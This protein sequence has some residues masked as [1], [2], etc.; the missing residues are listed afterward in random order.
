MPIGYIPDSFG[1]I[2]AIPTILAG[3]GMDTA[4]VY[5]GFGGEP[6]QETSEY[7]WVGPD[8]TRCLM[9]HLFRNGYS[10]GYFHQESD[11]EIV[12]RFTALKE[13]LDA[14]ATTSHRLLLNGGDH[15]WPDPRLPETIDLLTRSFPGT[16]VHSTLPAYV[17]GVKA[18]RGTLPE[19]R[20]E[21][22][23]GYRY[24]FAVLGGIYSSRMPIKQANWH[25]QHLLQRYAEPLNALAVTQ[26]MRT[27]LPLLHHAWNSLMQNHPHDS[28]CGCSIDPVHR[29]METRFAAVKDIGRAIV[30]ASLDHVIPYDDLASRDDRY[31]FFFNPTPW[32]RS[33]VVPAE[34]RFFRQDIVVGL[35][36]DVQVERPLPRATGFALVDR[37]GKEV[38]YQ[39]LSRTDGYDLTTT[40]FNYPKQT[41]A[42]CFSLLVDARC[43]P[44]I[45][46]AGL[47]VERRKSFPRYPARV[48]CGN[49]FLENEALRVDVN[50]RGEITLT[51]KARNIVYPGLGVC[52]DTGDV[53]DE[54]NYA[55]PR[56]DRRILSSAG[57]IRR[58]LAE[59]GPLR[60]TLRLDAQ[61]VLPAEAAPGRA[62][63]SRSTVKVPVTLLLHLSAD[64]RTLEIEVTVDNRARDHRFRILFP[65]G[66]GSRVSVADA[67][68][69]LAERTQ[70]EYDLRSFTIEH[71][72]RVAPMQRFVFAAGRGRALA[73]LAEGLPE[74]ELMTDRR[75][76]L[77]VTLL[78]SVGLL[79]GEDLLTRP[80][81]KSGWHNETPDAQCPG[82][83]SFR[84]AVLPLSGTRAEDLETLNEE[85]ERFHLPL[86]PVRRKNPESLPLE[87]SLLSVD[88][89][90]LVFSALKEAEDGDG[91]IV[92][93]YNPGAVAEEARIRFAVPLRTACTARLDETPLN[94]L[95][96]EEG[97]IV[98]LSFLAGQVQ[99][100]RV[101]TAT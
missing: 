78:R 75:S 85:S 45:G 1:H 4:L 42:D 86:Y 47:V 72:A 32:R 56:R 31:L 7:E 9:L 90:R 49:W 25:C 53:G 84:L 16:F 22:R 40:H 18:G 54:Y 89:R 10:A 46:V 36:P 91:I 63:R 62:A 35:N 30:T 19:V 34:V 97:N 2:A 65:T 80:G 6:G 99:T 20:G 74:Y 43:V 81:G 101:R 58:S 29:E 8:G 76:T 77:A 66:T 50:A 3:F 69:C 51:D 37:H 59:R 26:G 38:P 5:R 88:N 14:R 33:D 67:Q 60:A 57:R 64:A 52:E 70:E 41:A 17:E 92:R 95:S 55:Y 39:I 71:P 73:V 83:R 68:F 98:R 13:E 96:M 23:F 100:I 48:R 93:L 44:P 24:A 27:T 94:D 82:V 28:I 21:L 15:H 87:G 11:S 12:E 79:A 61:M